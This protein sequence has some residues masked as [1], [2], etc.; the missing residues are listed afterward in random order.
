KE[1]HEYY[2]SA[3]KSKQTHPT[4]VALGSHP[5]YVAG[6]FRESTILRNKEYIIPSFKID[7]VEHSTKYDGVLPCAYVSDIFPLVYGLSMPSY[8]KPC[9]CIGYWFKPTS[10]TSKKYLFSV[11]SDN[12]T[13][14]IDVY[15]NTSKQVVLEIKELS[16]TT[17]TLLTTTNLV[18]LNDWNF[19]GLSFYNRSDDGVTGISEYL[20]VLNHKKYIYKKN[21]SCFNVE[22]GSKPNYYVGC[23]IYGAQTSLGLDCNITA[24]MIGTRKHVTIEQMEDY[25]KVTRDFVKNTVL[26]S[27]S[28]ETDFSLTTTFPLGTMRDQFDIFPLETNGDSLN[29]T[30]PSVFEGRTASLAG[31]ST[32][33]TF[34]RKIKRYAFEADGTRLEYQF[35]ASSSRTILCRACIDEDEDKSTILDC[36]DIK[37]NRI[38]LYRK[39]NTKLYVSINTIEKETSL[40][41]SS[42]S[43]HTVGI[44]YQE[45]GSGDSAASASINVRVYLDGYNYVVSGGLH[46]TLG[47]LTVSVGKMFTLGTTYTLGV[48]A[49]TYPL[50]GHIEMLAIRAAYCDL[51]TLNELSNY[52]KVPTR[53]KSFDEMGLLRS[54]EQKNGETTLLKS[55]QTYRTRAYT[56]DDSIKSLHYTKQVAKEQ[57]TYATNTANRSYEYYANGNIKT[58]TDTTFGSHSYKYNERGFLS[59]DDST[60][61]LYDKN[62]NI[63]D[64]GSSHFTYDSTIKDRLVSVNGMAIKYEDSN[65]PLNPTSYGANKYSYS[66]K[67]LTE[68][69][70][71]DEKTVHI[72]YNEQG[73]IAKKTLTVMVD[74]DDYM[75]EE[76]YTYTYGYDRDNL[77]YENGKNGEFHFL[78]DETGLL[79]SFIRNNETY[80]YVRDILQNIIGIID[81]N[82]KLV[83][84]YD[85]TAYG[86][87]KSI[88]G[89]NITLA[90]ANPFRYKG[91]YYDSDL[92]MYYCKSRYYNPIWC[93][94]L[95][96]DSIENL[97]FTNV[98]NMNLFAYCGNNPVMYVDPSG[99]SF[100]LA[101]VAAVAGVLI[102]GV[103]N[104]F[105][106]MSG[107]GEDESAGGAFLVG[108]I[109]G[110]IS[111]TALAVGLAFGS[112][113]LGFFITIAGAFI[114]GSTGN[115]VGQKISYGN[116]DWRAS[117]LQGTM[118]AI[119]NI[120][121]Y[122]ASDMLGIGNKQTKFVPKVL[123]NMSL[124][125]IDFAVTAYFSSLPTFNFNK[126][127][128]GSYEN[129]S[130]LS[131]LHRL[132]PFNGIL[133]H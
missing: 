44:S 126:I 98:N 41:M 96:A 91:Y 45:A 31:A 101:L 37:G 67:R 129:Q 74:N 18:K 5:N 47:K 116:V 29:G 24:L 92:G 83:V 42:N 49:E 58:I 22:V 32:T 104:G 113:P 133:R 26:L 128:S 82:G 54:I 46:S 6:I 85:Y 52:M 64:I 121:L 95:N 107:R 10:L 127:R 117:F 51:S 71:G 79:Y 8:G 100:I 39:S 72:D 76:V 34:D 15:I 110:V 43:Y 120:V 77:I 114:G 103:M 27:S 12:Q 50:Y 125:P 9:G 11:Q 97:D 84:K 65:N 19:F 40:Y 109:D 131:W 75:E 63:T 60:D 14:R 7:G 17:H 1:F 53:V 89:D 25:Y 66:G 56:A 111:S 115:A 36:K 78:Y 119:M 94:W 90:H 124:M 93:R 99:G 57:I 4:N 23:R 73:L 88:S 2:F 122:K 132:F 62:G 69:K 86:Q 55:A 59:K 102:S 87:L 28:E 38:T 106:T 112:N 35:Q 80:Y 61:Y 30:K 70:Y 105:A 20:L 48:L 16:G 81:K 13:S 123:E 68:Y 21:G 33:F 130:F 118:S 3:N 108:F